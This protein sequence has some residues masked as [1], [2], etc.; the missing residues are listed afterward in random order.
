MHAFS[1][2]IRI[3]TLETAVDEVYLGP[4]LYYLII[5]LAVIRVSNESSTV[6]MRPSGHTPGPWSQTWNQ[7]TGMGPFKQLL[8]DEIALV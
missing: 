7:P 8:S 2:H 5:D 4:D 6:F 3:L 1:P